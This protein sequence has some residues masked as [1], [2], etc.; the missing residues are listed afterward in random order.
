ML[1]TAWENVTNFHGVLLD[2]KLSWKQHTNDVSTKISKTIG[3]FC[4]YFFYSLS[5]ELCKYCLNKHLKK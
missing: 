4:M 1:Q 5:F 3:I 2:E